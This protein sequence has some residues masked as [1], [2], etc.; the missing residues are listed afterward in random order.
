LRS[1]VRVVEA[2]KKGERRRKRGEV[3]LEREI[4]KL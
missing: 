2:R 3:C 4:K 1:R